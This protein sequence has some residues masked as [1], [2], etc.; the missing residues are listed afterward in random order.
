MQGQTHA[1]GD[2]SVEFTTVLGSCVAACLYDP[3]A[4][5]GGMNHF[6]L[7]TPAAQNGV[8]DAAY[9]LFLM[10]VLVNEMLKRGATRNGMRA[11]LYGGANLGPTTRRIGSVNSAFARRFLEVEGIQLIHADL[12]GNAARRLDFRPAQGRARC[13]IVAESPPEASPQRFSPSAVG[14]VELF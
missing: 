1:S 9:G 5:V 3:L 6:L 8:P 2:H 12:G 14:V 7:A 13:R 11:H 10:E 4:R